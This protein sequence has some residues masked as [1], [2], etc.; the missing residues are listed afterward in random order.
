MGTAQL[1]NYLSAAATKL[2]AETRH[3]AARMAR[4]RSAGCETRFREVR[5]REA[6]FRASRVRVARTL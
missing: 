6:R 5:F 1:R 2:G 3:V 4:E